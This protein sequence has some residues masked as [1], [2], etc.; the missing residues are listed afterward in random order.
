MK[1][2]Y[3][4]TIS[5]VVL[6]SACNKNKELAQLKDKSYENNV[7]YNVGF[8]PV[9]PEYKI[10][11]AELVENFYQ[12]NIKKPGFSGGFLMA[13]NGEVIFEDYDGYSNFALKEKI[14]ANTP[15]H[16]ASVGKVITAVTVLRLVD[17]K[18]INLD[19]SVSTYLED[20]PYKEIT[21]RQLLNHRS[22]LPYYGNFTEIPGIWDRK[23]TLT[24]NDVI[25]LLKNTAEIKL[26]SKP[27]TRFKYCNT[28]Y[29]LLASIVEKV[30]GKTFQEALKI[31]IL[32]PLKMKDTFVFDDIKNKDTVTQ[33]YHANNKKMHWDYLDGTYGD[34]NIY[35]TPRDMLKLDKAL[36]SDQFLSKNMKE[37]MFKGYSYEKVGS[38]NY[39]LGFRLI[40]P[41]EGD[42][43]T[44]HNGWWRG[45]KTSFVTLQKDTIAIICFNN[46][47]SA[48]AYKTK[49]LAAEFGNFPFITKS[50][51]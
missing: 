12:K 17:K 33:S 30:T 48:L 9:S 41:K 6:L 35:T 29:V 32:N 47:N 45:N 14:N 49:E 24:N 20:F 50:K 4:K 7:N 31:L 28:N 25:E 38:N 23:Q 1:Y 16:V 3:I 2:L 42:T 21:V 43:Y 36:Y 51:K 37:Q 8:H 15:M 44:F 13:K 39:G 22:G 5:L 34:K 18:K 11:T 10:E 27:N 19:E 40:E 46:K 26:E